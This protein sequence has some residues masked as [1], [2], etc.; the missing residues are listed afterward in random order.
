VNYKGALPDTFKEGAE[1][2]VTGT[3]HESGTM[4]ATD[5][6]AKCASRYEEKLGP[7]GKPLRKGS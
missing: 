1:V 7:D 3:L 5:V 6:L 4:A 2:V